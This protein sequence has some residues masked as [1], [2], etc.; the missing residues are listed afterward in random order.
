MC[1][2]KIHDRGGWIEIRDMELTIP[3]PLL[4]VCVTVLYFLALRLKFKLFSMSSKLNPASRAGL[5][6]PCVEHS[7]FNRSTSVNLLMC[8]DRTYIIDEN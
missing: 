2:V 7:A 8:G 3:Y 6:D 5:Q 4:P 1:T